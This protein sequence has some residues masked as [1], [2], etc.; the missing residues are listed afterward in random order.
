[1]KYNQMDNIKRKC[2]HLCLVIW[3]AQALD[4][5]GYDALKVAAQAEAHVTRHGANG[6]QSG[7]FIS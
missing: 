2:S 3:I 6:L 1:M 7:S 4:E 5:D